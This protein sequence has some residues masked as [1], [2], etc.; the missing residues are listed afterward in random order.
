M[1]VAKTRYGGHN[2]EFMQFFVLFCFFFLQK[3]KDNRNILGTQIM[4]EIISNNVNRFTLSSDVLGFLF[5][6][7]VFC[8][9]FS[10]YGSRKRTGDRNLTFRRV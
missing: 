10:A 8:C 2:C 7:L 1:Y 9:P 6:K 3:L 5:V 4:L